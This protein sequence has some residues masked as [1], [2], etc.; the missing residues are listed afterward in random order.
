MILHKIT[1]AYIRLVK[2]FINVKTQINCKTESYF[3][4]MFR[5]VGRIWIRAAG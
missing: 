2:I 1:I 5:M 3:L 4:I